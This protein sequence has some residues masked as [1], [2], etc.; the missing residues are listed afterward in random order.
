MKS[1]LLNLLSTF[2]EKTLNVLHSP[3]FSKSGS[4]VSGAR[5]IDVAYIPAVSKKNTLIPVVFKK[6]LLS[7]TLVGCFLFFGIAKSNAAFVLTYSSLTTTAGNNGLSATP[8]PWGSANYSVLGFQL[9]PSGTAGS[10]TI[11]TLTFSQSGTATSDN[12]YYTTAYL[13]SCTTNNFSTGTTALLAT[14][15]ANATTTITFNTSIAVANTGTTTYY[16]VVLSNTLGNTANTFRIYRSGYTYTATTGTTT[17]LANGATINGPSYT[18]AAS[19]VVTAADLTGASLTGTTLI[20]GQTNIAVAGVSFVTNTST[21]TLSQLIF[22]VSPSTTTAFSYFTN[23]PT[24]VTCPTSTYSSAS[25]TAVP[26]VG[27]TF[28]GTTFTFNLSPA[29]TVSTTTSYYF[30]VLNYS[31]TG[32]AVPQIFTFNPSSYTTALGTVTPAY[33]A[34]TYTCE[35]PPAISYTPSTTALIAGVAMTTLSP[36]TTGGAVAS[37][38]FG[39]GTALTGATLSTPYGIGINPVNGDIYVTNSGNATIS[40]Y[41]AAGTYVGTF[42]SGFNTPVGIVFDSAGNAYVADRGTNDVYKISALGVKTTLITGFTSLRG[43]AIDASN[44]LYVVS[45]G[46]NAVYQYSTSGT[47]LLTLNN[48]NT[49]YPTGA[50]IDGSGNIYVVD[51]TNGNVIKYNSSGAYVSTFAAG[52]GTG[53]GNGPYAI[54][55]DGSGNVYVSDTVNNQV[56][57]YNSSGT[58]IATITG[59]NTPYGLAVDSSGNLYVVNQGTPS[60]V[61][62]PLTGGYTISGTLPAGLSFNSST[63][64]ISGTPTV[65]FSS[66]T[67]TIK[68]YNAY[69]SGSTTVTLSCTIVTPAFHYSPSTNVYSINTAITALSP[70]VTAGIIGA[71][72]FG[73]GTTFSSTLNAPYGVTVGPSGNIYVADAN[74]GVIREYSSSGTYLGTFGVTGYMTHPL[75]IVFDSSGNAYV[76][77]VSGGTGVVYKFSSTGAYVATLNPRGGTGFISG[78]AIAIDA[79]NNLFVSETGNGNVYEFTTAGVSSNTIAITGGNPEGIVTDPSGNFYVVGRGNR[80][81]YKY[82]AAGTLISTV[83]TGLNTPYGLA[84]DGSGNLYVG[85]SGTGLVSEYNASG[86]LITSISGLTNPEGIATDASDNVYVTDATNGTLIKYST[87]GGYYL[88]GTLPA[89][90]SF[91]N[92]TGVFTGTPTTIF[93][94]TTYTVT[95]YSYGV[96]GTTTVTLSCILPAPAISYTPSTDVYCDGTAITALLPVNTGGAVSAM[97]YSAGTQIT[98]ATLNSPYGIGTDASGNIYVTNSGSGNIVKYTSAGV[99]S[100]V[101]ATGLTT[102]V[103][104]VFD[105]SGNA[106]VIDRGTNDVVKITTAGVQSNIITGYTSLRGIAIDASNN[107]YITDGFGNGIY[108]YS[109][110]GALLMTLPA[111]HTAYPT[112]IAVDASG[113]IYVLDRTNNNIVE[114][115]SSGTYVTT[116]ATGF[117]TAYGLSIDAA[118]NVYVA[119]SGNSKIEVYNSTGTLLT[120][121]TSNLSTPYGLITD[122]YGNIYETNNGNTRVYKYT[123]TGNFSISPALPTGLAFN[124]VTGAITGTPTTVTSST[125]YTISCSNTT[126]TATTTVNITTGSCSFADWI[127]VTSSDWNTASNWSTGVVPTSITTADIGVNQTFLNLPNIGPSGAATNSVAAVV[128]GSSSTKITAGTSASAQ[129][130]GFVV[131]TGH[132]LN[133]G[134]GITYQS[135]ANAGT[136]TASISGA[137]IVNAGSLNVIANTTLAASY[138]EKLTSSVNNF[139]ISGNIV[140][141]STKPGTKAFNATCSITGGTAAVTGII[142]T[143][144]AAGSTSSFTVTPATTATLQLANSAALSGLSATGTNVVTFNNTGATVEYSGAGQTV[145]TDASITGLTTGP[146]YYSIKFSG[147][148]I[149]APNGT[150]ANNI[151]ISR[152]FT[153]SLTLNDATD[154]INLSSPAVIF[155]GTTQ[156]IY[157]GNG[158]GTTFYNTTFSG[159]GTTT[160]QSGNM[161]EASSGVLTMSGSS[162]VLAAGGLLTLNSDVTGSATVA[163]IPTGCSITGN[164]NVQRLITG[165]ASQYRGYRLLSSAVNAGSGDYSINYLKNSCFLTG[166]TGTGGGFDGGVNPTLYLFR[167]NLVPSGASFTSGNF[168]GISNISASPSYSINV[169][170]SGF[171]IPVGNGFLFFFRGDRNATGQTFATET[172]TTYVPTTTTLTETGPLNQ[173]AIAVKDWYTPASTTLGYTTTS[174]TPSIEGFNL[175]GNPYPSSIDWDTYSTTLSASGIYAPGVGPF[176][177]VLD[178]KSKNYNVY[179]AGT[180]GAGTIANTN[181]NVIPSGQGF[182]VIAGSAASLTFNEAAKVNTQVTAGAGNLF[183]GPPPVAA[184]S[185]YMRLLLVK[186]SLNTDGIVINFNNNAKPQYVP[187]E[188][189]PYKTGNGPVSLGSFSSDSVSLAINTLPLPK[190]SQIIPLKVNANA[191]GI[192]TLNM[193]AIKDVPQLFEIWLMDTYKKDSLDIRNNPTYSFNVVKSDASSYGPK[194]FYLFIRQN[195]A[196]ALHLLNFAGSKVSNGAQIV[197]QTENEQNYTNFTVERSTDGGA[198]FNVVGGF[199]SN[200]QGTYSLL[201]KN[202]AM[203]SDQ[204]R[205]KLEDLNGA[206]SYSKVVTLI[207][208]NGDNIV[209]SRIN[210]YPNPSTD[211]INLEIKQNGNNGSSTN[212]PP[213]QNIATTPGLVS[214][215]PGVTSSYDIKIINSS[216]TVMKTA[217]SSSTNWE[218]SVNNLMPG[219]Y[220]IQ[221]I[222]NANKKLVGRNTFVKL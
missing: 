178:S 13:Y 117:N 80:A 109:T 25:A 219:T 46:G 17:P 104:I 157:A 7:L 172:V 207:Y 94:P 112:G 181:A 53:G 193:S 160:I 176:I 202:P 101:Y 59:L 148:G 209:T 40:Y 78:F 158:T 179:M 147:T 23:P 156:N 9:A 95:A 108:K 180:G 98:G 200:T 99:Y 73:T 54:A 201:D 58:L 8:V 126:G 159:T 191:N 20:Q 79:S 135:D 72:G 66:T 45:G 19:P 168:R 214:T 76:L 169:D 192:Y 208:G 68:A 11:N 34:N 67:Y 2:A 186:D 154:Y 130:G 216:G 65:A 143:S 3:V 187:G 174:G 1:F 75:R 41:T 70:I 132:T 173:G 90:L 153:N 210:V 62:Y 124:T 110:G 64:T 89:G 215:S 30:L 88:T 197:W 91:S 14:T 134:G 39:T 27:S 177:Y 139:N 10:G 16:F 87:I 203:A 63:G 122:S 151:N 150:A 106:Y 50:A 196:L 204:Y 37:F 42:S 31:V 12:A 145:Y 85:D 198:T 170:G 199:I 57:V 97:S 220:I 105:S 55:V 152:D 165:G 217:T 114:F 194:R 167:E 28:A 190:Q 195:P 84:I 131:N 211:I 118:G 127:G 146:S 48:T 93:G 4:A 166:T 100:A 81:V 206:I 149:K 133:V 184:V 141:T 61:K 164:V 189:A 29:A 123:V 60:V 144:N 129:A 163:A 35:A 103:G 52:F 47:L 107:L 113:N 138:T 121:F 116:F 77:N 161:Y 218:G 188:D 83:V 22:T 162:A 74:N 38:G 32:G 86:T 175:L 125:V 44:N 56:K 15:A 183:L 6:H 212:L 213:L 51:R 36:T 21:T 128:I 49:A 26:T 102:P 205:L 111:T 155:N 137:G 43:I 5:D 182:F 71:P 92:T 185:R 136:L 33:T 171:N 142:Q 24:L 18:F 222:N 82:N 221:V 140:L 115:N 69:G 119:D 96:P 120:S